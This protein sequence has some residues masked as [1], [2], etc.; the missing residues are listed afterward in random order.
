MSAITP[1]SAVNATNARVTPAKPTKHQLLLQLLEYETD[2]LGSV[3]SVPVTENDSA[4]ENS[5][6]I[7]AVKSEEVKLPV[8]RPK[9]QLTEKQLEALK[10]GQEKRDENRSKNKMEKMKK[11]EEEKKII[12]EK[13]VKKA[14]AIK[15]KQIKKQALLNEIS[16]AE[17]ETNPPST[18]IT[19]PKEAPQQIPPPLPPVKPKP[20]IRFV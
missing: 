9:K 20:L 10:K 14:I 5:V 7:D 3:G 17:E 16:D 8:T 12:E 1:N 13:L 18:P 4:D 6:T 2:T 15:K 19:K 11:E